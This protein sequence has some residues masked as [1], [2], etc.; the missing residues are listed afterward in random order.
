MDKFWYWITG[1]EGI[2]RQKT[3][4]LLDYYV[5]PSNV[6][7]EALRNP[8]R[9]LNG[10]GVKDSVKRYFV[11][12]LRFIDANYEALCEKC[13][14]L[15]IKMV[16]VDD[17][18]Y[19]H[20][21]KNAVPVPYVLYY[22]GKLPDK[23]RPALCVIGSRQCD[24]YGMKIAYLVSKSLASEG[25]QI[26]SGLA[27][28]ID[29]S[30]HDGALAGGDTYAVLGCGVDICYPPSNIDT[31]MAITKCGGIISEYP[32]SSKAMKHH[33]PER[34]RIISGLSDG[35]LV[36]QARKKSGS[37]ITVAHALE[38]GKNVYVIPGRVTDELSE[39]CLNLIK[40]GAKCVTCT[41]DILEDFEQYNMDSDNCFTKFKDNNAKKIIENSL[42]T[43]EKIV[44]ASLRLE[45]RH[46]EEIRKDT[47]LK[48]QDV[49]TALL[50]LQLKGYAQS[51]AVNYYSIS[52]T[53]MI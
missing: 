51:T 49:M 2:G 4:L 53:N 50:K 47:G 22:K 26:I 37:L 24:E 11:D 5:T 27:M 36:V 32:P 48:L 42:E 3:K 39:G 1:I 46:I 15:G 9:I 6:Y 52:L 28:G 41:K 34:N 18:D 19:P 35:I 13:Q 40:E 14:R 30:A 29:K 10:L 17:D 7:Q 33:F 21:L 38:Q 12:S 8:D 44:Y 23:K 45:S 16:C 25:V 31:Y 43:T 20:Q